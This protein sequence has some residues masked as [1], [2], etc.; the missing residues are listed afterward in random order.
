MNLRDFF[1][2]F[3]SLRRFHSPNDDVYM[4]F[5]R[6]IWPA[7]EQAQIDHGATDLVGI[8]AGCFLP[9]PDGHVLYHGFGVHDRG[10]C[11]AD[12]DEINAEAKPLTVEML[13]GAIKGEG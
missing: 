11:K 8:C 3:H 6:D 9:M 10:E 5:W 1:I 12:A 13:R 7:F 2:I 4:M